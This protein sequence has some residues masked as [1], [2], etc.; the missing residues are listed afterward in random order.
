MVDD[1]EDEWLR[2]KN[3]Y[4]YI[5]SRHMVM[6]VKNWPKLLKQALEYASLPPPWNVRQ[7]ANE[8]KNSHLKPGGWYEMQE[9]HHYPQC[10]D[11]SMPVD[12]PVAQFWSYVHQGLAALN[13]NFGAVLHLEDKM[14]EAGFVNISVRVFH[15]PI[16][17]W[18]KNRLLKTVG[19]YWREILL[20]G[21]EPIALGPFTRGLKWT[22]EQVEVFLVQVRHSYGDSWCHSHMPLYI[23]CGQK[24]DK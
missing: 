22:R 12:H 1:V 13:V 10:H 3:H 6:A 8:G 9:I 11:G 2:P 23:I 14:R 15:V 18:P 4:D 5:H 20:L 17:V 19:L 16:G 7:C 24:P 21:V